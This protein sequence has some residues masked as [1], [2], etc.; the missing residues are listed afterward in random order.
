MHQDEMDKQQIIGKMCAQ[1]EDGYLVQISKNLS[2][3]SSTQI[4]T[5]T[6]INLTEPWPLSFEKAVSHKNKNDGLY[7]IVLLVGLL[8]IVLFFCID[9]LWQPNIDNKRP[10]IIPK[11]TM[12]S[13]LY[14]SPLP[15]IDTS[16]PVDGKVIPAP[17]DELRLTTKTEITPV[18]SAVNTKTKLDVKKTVNQVIQQAID[19]DAEKDRSEKSVSVSQAGL[20][21]QANLKSQVETATKVSLNASFRFDET[22]PL[23]SFIPISHISNANAISSGL[24]DESTLSYLQQQQASKV[25]EFARKQ[26][27]L[28]AQTATMSD[29]TPTPHALLSQSTAIPQTAGLPEVHGQLMDPNRIVQKGDF[30]YRMIKTPTQINPN[31]EIVSTIGYR[32]SPDEDKENV[33]NLINQRLKQRDVD[34]N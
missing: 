31:A 21:K 17:V 8:H 33:Q 2:V 11:E 24:L 29:M 19:Q 27:S 34:I 12:K 28:A 32:C 15:K 30:C 1:K 10:K 13:Y 23:T 16:I 3:F 14:V 7:L 20:I 9:K 22:D 18:S 26:A 5:V 25:S 6:K 4:D